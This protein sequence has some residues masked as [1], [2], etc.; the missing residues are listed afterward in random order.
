MSF[1]AVG[2]KPFL[3]GLADNHLA[4]FVSTPSLNMTNDQ[5]RRR[6]G[7]RTAGTASGQPKRDDGGLKPH[8]VLSRSHVRSVMQ[9]TAEGDDGCCSQMCKAGGPSGDCVAKRE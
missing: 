6:S 9:P 8:V 2:D 4:D 5:T 3:A 7:P 1:P